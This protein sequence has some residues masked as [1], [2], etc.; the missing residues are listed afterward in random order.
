MLFKCQLNVR[1]FVGMPKKKKRM[2][3]LTGLREG[4]R[5]DLKQQRSVGPNKEA[6]FF[7]ASKRTSKS[8]HGRSR[9]Y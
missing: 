3:R 7:M 1:S 6:H 2:E 4:R 9:Q 5:R 8:S